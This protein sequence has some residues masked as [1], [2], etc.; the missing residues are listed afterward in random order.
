MIPA[1]LIKLDLA[2]FLC[3]TVGLLVVHPR[4]H[5]RYHHAEGGNGHDPGVAGENL[6]KVVA[7]RTVEGKL[8]KTMLA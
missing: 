4:M 8:E 1:R 2:G 7:F 6:L 5:H 3:L